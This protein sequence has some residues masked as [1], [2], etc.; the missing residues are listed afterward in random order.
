MI[1][2]NKL[3][4]KRGRAVGEAIGNNS[5]IVAAVEVSETTDQQKALDVIRR[6]MKSTSNTHLVLVIKL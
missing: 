1:S 2:S 5:E 6:A 3:I 4:G